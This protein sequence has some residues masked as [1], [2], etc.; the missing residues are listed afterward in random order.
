[1]QEN[2]AIAT[3]FHH[4]VERL[5]GEDSEGDEREKMRFDRATAKKQ[6][7]PPSNDSS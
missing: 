2:P 1:M 5:D 6:I 3:I 4:S 7:L